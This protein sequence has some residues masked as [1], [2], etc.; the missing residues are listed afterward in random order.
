MM[1]DWHVL[2]LF[3]FPGSLPTSPTAAVGLTHQKDWQKEE[4]PS[5][6]Q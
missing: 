6:D 1:V 2:K 3:S 4:E 5:P